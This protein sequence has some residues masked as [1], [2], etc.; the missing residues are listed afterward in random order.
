MTELLKNLPELI[1]RVFDILELLVVRSTLLGLAAFGAYAL[2]T[3]A[4]THQG[5]S[6]SVPIATQ[7]EPGRELRN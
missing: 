1:N 4:M 6:D 5:T 3:K 7:T 2:L